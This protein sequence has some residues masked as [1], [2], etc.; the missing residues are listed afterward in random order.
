MPIGGNKKG[1]PG[2]VGPAF[3]WLQLKPQPRIGF[4]QAWLYK[5]GRPTRLMHLCAPE[6]SL[7]QV[8]P[9]PWNNHK[10]GW[11]GA[12]LPHLFGACVPCQ[13]HQPLVTG[14][15]PCRFP[16]CPGRPLSASTI[17]SADAWGGGHCWA[18]YKQEEAAQPCQGREE[19]RPIPWEATLQLDLKGQAESPGWG[20]G[21][22]R[23]WTP[24]EASWQKAGGLGFPE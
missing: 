15:L 16:I 9:S 18:G 7:D 13:P 5:G 10:N 6:S 20:A 21:G 24:G 17:Q 23:A 14:P 12:G 8:C 11:G 22:G 1:K 19:P 3:G 4:C 2:G